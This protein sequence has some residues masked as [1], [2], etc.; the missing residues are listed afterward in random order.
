[1]HAERGYPGR[2]PTEPEIQP[3][4]PLLQT[5]KVGTKDSRLEMEGNKT[6]RPRGNTSRTEEI[7]DNLPFWK[8]PLSLLPLHPLSPRYNNNFGGPSVATKE[9]GILIGHL[10][11]VNTDHAGPSIRGT[12][13]A[14]EG[15]KPRCGCVG[16]IPIWGC[17]TQQQ[18]QP[19]RGIFG[20]IPSQF[21]K[22]PAKAVRHC[23]YLAPRRD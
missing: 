15:T 19:A 2:H 20:V 10:R 21:H 5:W 3:P 8:H 13:A 16:R 11:R 17:N 1:M 18:Q 22:C 6:I 4:P 12:D 14:R 23:P 7:N 9:A